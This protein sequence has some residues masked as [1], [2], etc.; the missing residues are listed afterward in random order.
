MESTRILTELSFQNFLDCY[1]PDK[2]AKATKICCLYKS[3]LQL[4]HHKLSSQKR[5]YMLPCSCD[6]TVLGIKRALI[7]SSQS[8]T[9]ARLLKFFFIEVMDDG[10]LS[11][12]PKTNLRAEMPRR[13]YYPHRPAPSTRWHDRKRQDDP[14]MKVV[15][16]LVNTHIP[17]A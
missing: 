6:T 16:P 10:R 4:F 12:S 2:D 9:A 3:M 17:A 13:G 11:R 7:F 8:R 14:L 1:Q 5:K 15:Y